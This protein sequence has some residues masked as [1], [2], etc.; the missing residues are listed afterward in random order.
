MMLEKDPKLRPTM[1]EIIQMS[2]N[3]AKITEHLTVLG[4]IKRKQAKADPVAEPKISAKK[5]AK[6]YIDSHAVVYVKQK[7]NQKLDSNLPFYEQYTKL[8]KC[9]KLVA[10]GGALKGKIYFDSEEEKKSYAFVKVDGVD[11][12]IEVRGVNYLN[13]AFD[14]DEVYIKLYN[15]VQ[16][17]PAGSQ[18]DYMNFKRKV[19]EGKD[20]NQKAQED[21][22]QERD[23]EESDLD[24]DEEASG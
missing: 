21:L 11:M 24:I 15:W 19:G 23:E 18:T 3:E 6:K 14:L 7:D 8:D 2:S 20:N 1:K 16:W 5:I 12:P 22:D 10:Q 17:E 13:G 4:K 9:E